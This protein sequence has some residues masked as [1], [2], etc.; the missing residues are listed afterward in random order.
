MII[1]PVRSMKFPYRTVIFQHSS[2]AYL[3][4]NSHY[5]MTTATENLLSNP[6]L[7]KI[8]QIECMVLRL[9]G[10]NVDFEIG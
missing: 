9:Q 5:T 3:Q 8:L 6:I 10:Y 7:N 2:Q 4:E 1:I